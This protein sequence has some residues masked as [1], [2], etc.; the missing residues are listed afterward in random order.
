MKL[1]FY[2]CLSNQH[3]DHL[4][5]LILEWVWNFNIFI[6][7][8]KKNLYLTVCAYAHLYVCVWVWVCVSPYLC[9]S[10]C[11]FYHPSGFIYIKAVS[12]GSAFCVMYF[13]AATS[14]ADRKT[15][16]LKSDGLRHQFVLWG[17]KTSHL[18]C[19]W[20]DPLVVC[21]LLVDSLANI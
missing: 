16:F 13:S 6:I 5:L 11:S 19:I 4:L 9:I 7:K 10:W 2:C 20:Y 8:V 21:L 15:Y 3:N 1:L 14:A 12:H 18:P 17:S